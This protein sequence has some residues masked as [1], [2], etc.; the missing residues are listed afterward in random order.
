MVAPSLKE[1]STLHNHD[2]KCNPTKY[3]ENISGCFDSEK[4]TLR[5]SVR[6]RGWLVEGGTQ[7]V[8]KMDG[9]SPYKSNGIFDRRWAGECRPQS[10]DEKE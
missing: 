1:N 4:K 3:L 9:L 6:T 8:V 2:V 7:P 10:G 5:N